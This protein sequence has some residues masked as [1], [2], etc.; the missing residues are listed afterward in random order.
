MT[1]LALECSV[2]AAASSSS[3]NVADRAPRDEHVGGQ[4]LALCLRVGA[5]LV[6]TEVALSTRLHICLAALSLDRSIGD[7]SGPSEPSC[8]AAARQKLS[9][10]VRRRRKGPPMDPEKARSGSARSGHPQHLPAVVLRASPERFPRRKTKGRL[11]S[12]PLESLGEHRDI[13]N[14]GSERQ[15]G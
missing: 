12:A 13:Y 1:T 11:G 7:P 14:I 4:S 3:S 8:W 9:L 6:A 10:A 5:L 15:H 2:Q